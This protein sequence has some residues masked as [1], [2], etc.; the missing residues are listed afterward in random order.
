MAACTKKDILAFIERAAAPTQT[1]AAVELPPWEQPGSGDLFKPTDDLAPSPS[2]RRPLRRRVRL[3]AALQPGDRLVPLDSMR[4]RIAEHMV[5]SKL[6]TAPHATTVFEVDM[7]AVARHRAAHKADFAAQGAHLTYTAY[8]V[9]ALAGALRRHPLANSQWT[10]DGILLKGAIHVGLAVALEA[11]LIVPVIRNADELS[12]LGL[13]RRVGDLA[14]RARRGDLKPDEVSGGTFTL[15]NHGVSGS[16]FATPIINQPQS[17]ILG[18]GAIQKRV[19]VLEGDA[20]AVRPMGYL[21][22]TF[23][24]RVLDGATADAFLAEIKRALETWES[25]PA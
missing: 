12:L 1:T 2:P 4:R 23:D 3:Q 24:H 11:G 9:A 13:A 25:S 14:E 8:I 19:V 18:V 5:L 22:F 17:G 6:H 7:S 21:S 20:L 16:L 10:A 15:T